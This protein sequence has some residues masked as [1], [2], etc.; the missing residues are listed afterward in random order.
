MAHTYKMVLTEEN[1]HKLCKGMVRLRHAL[2][3]EI[4]GYERPGND[5][6]RY[7][8]IEVVMQRIRMARDIEEFTEIY[9]TLISVESK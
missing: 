7:H 1:Y 4:K 5:L 3:E 8:G 9:T 2:N 6:E